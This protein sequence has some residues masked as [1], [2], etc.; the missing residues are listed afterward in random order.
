MRNV[1]LNTTLLLN[2]DIPQQTRLLEGVSIKLSRQ[3]FIF[4]P[5]GTPAGREKRLSSL[6]VNRLK[7]I[8]GLVLPAALRQINLNKK[9]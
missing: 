9:K 3:L 1:L 2:L 7:L 8:L 6:E 5:Y 4:Q